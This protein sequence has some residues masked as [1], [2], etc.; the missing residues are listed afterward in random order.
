MNKKNQL[1]IISKTKIV[2]FIAL[3]SMVLSVFTAFNGNTAIKAIA[4]PICASPVNEPLPTTAGATATYTNGL[5]ANYKL[6]SGATLAYANQ[7]I[8]GNNVTGFQIN[9]TSE[10]E[11]KY[12]PVLS[13][14]D[15]VFTDI[16]QTEITTFN[17]YDENNNLIE[18]ITPY[19]T[20]KGTNVVSTSSPIG[21]SLEFTAA[22]NPIAVTDPVGFLR[23]NITQKVSR[24]VIKRAA[25]ALNLNLVFFTLSACIPDP[26][27]APGQIY[28][29]LDDQDQDGVPNWTDL[30][31]DNDG[32]LDS[33]ECAPNNTGDRTYFGFREDLIQSNF[34]AVLAESA[35]GYS[36]YG[37]NI[38]S[39]NGGKDYLVPTPITAAN[40]FTCT[41]TILD[42][43]TSSSGLN[44]NQTFILTTTGLWVYGAEGIAVN[45]SLTSSTTMQQIAL[46]PGVNPTDVKNILATNDPLLILTNSGDIW[47]NGI[48]K[49]AVYGDGSTTSNTAWHKASMPEPAVS[50]RT[51]MGSVIAMTA[52]GKVYT[53]GEK[54]YD[55]VSPSTLG[56]SNVRLP[57]LQTLPAG[58]VPA[59]IAI[60]GI[61]NYP[62]YYVLGTNGKV[63][64]LGANNYGHAGTGNFTNV[65]KWTAVRNSTNTGDLENIRF[66]SAE[67]QDDHWASA[68]AIDNSGQL[69]SWGANDT[70][71]IAGPGGNAPLP[72]KPLGLEGKKVTYVENGGHL[73]PVITTDGLY[74]NTG[75]NVAGGFGDGTSITRT[76]YECNKIPEPLAVFD[77]FCDDDKDGIAN[78]FDLDNDNDTIPDNVESQST[79]GYKAVT[80]DANGK[81]LVG[82]TG[83]PLAYDQTLGN[84]P[85]DT[86][87][88]G[89]P[90]YLDL[91]SDNEGGNDIVEVGNGAADTNNDG[92]TNNP[93]GIN[94]LD[95]TKETADTYV[96]PNGNINIPSALP[97]TQNPATPE[98]DY[99]DLPL[100]P[101]AADDTNTTPLNT[102]ITYNPLANDSYP[103]GTKITSIN[104]ITVVLGTPIIVPN[105]TV[106]VNLDGS[107]TVTPSNGY[108]GDVKFPYVISSVL[109][110]NSTANDTVTI[111]AAGALKLVKAA[112]LIDANADG[113]AQVGEPISYTFT[114]TNSST[115]AVNNITLSDSKCSPIIGGPIATLAPGASDSTTFKCVYKLT[116]GDIIAKKVENQATVQGTDALGN[117]V[118]TKSDSN[119]TTKPGLTDPTVTP[120]ITKAGADLK[121]SKIPDPANASRFS[122]VTW[123]ILVTNDGPE[124][125]VNPV[126]TDT[127]P[128]GL[129]YQSAIP[130]STTSSPRTWTL[131]TLAPGASTTILMKTTVNEITPQTNNASVKSITADPDLTNN[132]T[133]FTLNGNNV[134][135]ADL[136][137]KKTVSPN[138]SKVGDTVTYTIAVTNNGPDDAQNTSVSDTPPAGL[139]ILTTNPT[140]STTPQNYINNGDFEAGNTGFGYNYNYIPDTPTQCQSDAYTG[141][142]SVMDSNACL[143]HARNIY[144]STESDHTTPGTREGNYL[145]VNAGTN[146]IPTNQTVWEQTV[147]GLTPG[148]Q[149]K[150]CWW[151]SDAVMN[152]DV[153]VTFPAANTTIDGVE[154]QK[155]QPF[156]FL[157]TNKDSNWVQYCST[158][159]ADADGASTFKINNL[160]V[161]PAFANLHSND[162]VVDDITLV[163]VTTTGTNYYNTGVIKP[164]ETKLITYTALVTADGPLVN[165]AAV[166]SP[167]DPKDAGANNFATNTL[168]TIKEVPPV[169]IDDTKTT[170]L[171]TPITYAPLANDTY[172]AGSNITKINGITVVLGTPILVPNGTVTVNTDGTVTV[173]PNPGYV[174]DIKFPYEVTTPLGTKA[175]ANNTVTITGTGSVELIKSSTLGDTNANGY[176]DL[177][178]TVKYTFTVRNTGPLALTNV[179]ISDNKCSPIVGSPIATLAVGAS[180]NTAT[181]SYT[182]TAADILLGKV[183]NTATA[184]GTDPT[185]KPVADTSDD[186]NDPT[187]PGANDPTISLLIPKAIDD[188]NT[189]AVN[190]PVT[191]NPLSNDIVPTGSKITAIDGKPVTVG[192][193]IPVLNG[194]VTVNADGT[195]T[196]TP[197]P[198]YVGDIKFPYEVTTPTG[199]KV[200]ATDTVTITGTGAIEIIK[201]S[202]V[203]DTNGNGY[204]DVGDVIKYTFTVK[205][206]GPLVLTNVIISDNKCTPVAGSPIATLAVGASNNSATC[207][208]TL[209][210]ADIATGKV[211]NSATVSGTDP[212]GKQVNDTSDDGNDPTKP[213]LNDPTITLLTPKAIDDTNTTPINTP[214]TYA[215]LANDII[216]TGSKITSIN[217]ITVVPGTPIIVPNG[218]VTVNADG[219]ITV[220]PT[221]GFVGDI[222]FPYEVTT[223]AGV[224]VTANDT[225]TISGIGGIELVKTSTLGDTNANGYTDLGDTI[226]YTFTVKN[227]GTLPLT[228]V[229]ISDSKCSPIVGSPIATLAVGASNNTATCSYT[230]SAL[231]IATGK[232]ENT[233]TVTAKDPTGATL[234]DT[235]DDGNNPA[236]PGSNDPTVT[237]LIPKAVDD[238]NTTPLNT[239]I[240]YSP[241]A[242]DTIPTGSVITSNGQPVPVGVPLPVTNGTVTI[243]ANGT[244]TVTPDKDFVGVITFPYEVTTPQGV[245]V[246]AIDTVTITGSGKVEIIKTSTTID[247]NNNGYADL[248]DKLQYTFMVK[249]VGSLPL[250]DIVIADDKCSPIIGS[251]IATLAVGA[252]NN[253]STCEY[254][255]TQADLNAGKVV[256]TATATGKD[257]SGKVITDISDDGNDITQVGFDD[258][259][260]SLLKPKA[261]DDTKTTPLN[262]PV[263]YAPLANDIV[264]TGSKIVSI[265]GTVAVVGTPILVPNGTVTLNADGTV[266]VTPNQGY[267][268]IIKFPYDVL[269]PTNL[270][271]SATDTVTIT[272]T[273]GVEIAKASTLVDTNGNGY[274]DMGDTIKY[275]FAVKNTGTLP[276]TDVTIVDTK[277]SPITGSPIA[278]LAIGAVDN[279]ATCSYM[280]TAAD[281]NTGKVDN[282]ATVTAKDSSGKVLTDISDDANVPSTPGKDDP[283]ITLL[284]PKAID[285]NNTTPINTPVTYA[286]LTNDTVPTGSKIT[287]IDGKPVTVGTPIQVTN[288]T[289]TVNADGTITVTPNPGYVGD[290]KFPYEVTTP[291]GTKVIA[292]DTVTIT[293]S[294]SIEIIKT[295]V[296]VDTNNNG[297]TDLGD[298]IK[299]TFA[300]KNTGSLALTNVIIT[301]SKCS[302]ITGS[303]IASLLVGASNNSATCS[304]TITAADISIGKV[305]N[306]ATVSGTDPTGKPVT[307]TSDDGNDPTKPG[308]NDPTISLLIPKAIDDTNTTAVNTPV[309]YNPLS[310]DIVPTGS[311]ITAIDGKPVT[312]GTPIPVLNGTVTVNA[313]GTITV[314]PNPGY[315][316]DIKFPYEVT[317]PTVVKVTATDT[318]TITGTGAIELIKSSVFMDK[319][320][321]GTADVGDMIKY[322][323]NVKN[324]GPLALTNVTIT[325]NKCTPITSLPI[326]TLAI[327]SSNNTPTCD[328]TITAAD[329][330]A[331]KVTNSATATGTTPDGK[332]VTDISDDGNNPNT[333]GQV[334]PT[335]TPLTP[336]PIFIE[337]GKLEVIKA[338]QYIDTNNDGQAQAGETIKYTFT[339]KNTGNV[340]LTNVVLIDNKCSPIVGGPIATLTIGATD[341]T[342]FSCTYALLAEDILAGKVENQ[343]IARGQTPK[344]VSVVGISD[345]SDPSKTGPNDVTVTMLPKV[346][347]ANPILEVDKAGTLIDTN[348]NGASEVGE[349]IK[350]TF[351]VKN[352]G[353]VVL[354]NVNITDNKCSVVGGP[355]ASMAVGA[356]D[357][358]TF[359][360]TYIITAADIAAG[361]ADNQAQ[362]SGT[363][364]SGKEVTDLSNDPKTTTPNDVTS[365]L[366]TPKLVD[367][368]R[369]TPFNT[370]ITYSP[371]VND[372]IPAGSTITAI[373]GIPVLIGTPIKVLNGT[374]TVNNDGTVTVTPDTGYT[375]IINFPYEVTTP[376]GIK[377]LADEDITVNGKGMV[378]LDKV[379]SYTD[380]NNDGK[381]GLGET[382]KYAFTIKNTG[383]TILTNVTVTDPMTGIVMMGSPIPSLAPGATNSTA[384]YATYIVTQADLDKG[385]VINQ[386]T[387]SGLDPQGNIVKDL[388]NDPSTTFAKDPTLLLIPKPPILVP[389]PTPCPACTQLPAPSNCSNCP[390]P[391]A[392]M[393]GCNNGCNSGCCMKI[394][395]IKNITNTNTVTITGGSAP[396]LSPVYNYNNV[397]NSNVNFTQGPITFDFSPVTN[398]YYR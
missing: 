318:V 348:S 35:T 337:A 74:C 274:T 242:N 360:C 114:V 132:N 189:T 1:N 256:N 322:T 300:V 244:I 210:A 381:L 116:A 165:K 254:T 271:V 47:T 373:N 134:N 100:P 37:V 264:P 204:S 59:Q 38:G 155:I 289:V 328:Y 370:P 71:M 29:V 166:T 368:S 198:G 115:I 86:D 95:N 101:V 306:T 53:W 380:A 88:D 220:T 258:P 190:T 295:S 149:Y 73:T 280:I 76:Q 119:D 7:P 296:L 126:V 124:P 243:N 216:P 172:P 393:N 146:N 112:Q 67:D 235:S 148:K 378:E 386:A 371:L 28:S 334:D 366:L 128:A 108:L 40:G 72:I 171:N 219:T 42:A 118:T 78:Q 233:A 99:R 168:N 51:W 89:T 57:Y 385:M 329:L 33:V 64:T 215:P 365:I 21:S 174:G 369:V 56:N 344:G 197:N 3:A 157:T 246:T 290:I 390:S 251:P 309:T 106:T 282:T 20:L 313:D 287:A 265:N 221:T 359:T 117:T 55:G 226:K 5:S 358:T 298:T 288:G 193:P 379:A 94:G 279:T 24:I 355:V 98:V 194:T 222:K 345:S 77:L 164:G 206:S 229:I 247:S 175:T 327:G 19:I 208:Y 87:K 331:L 18:D 278:S 177:G 227:S 122:T 228:N 310:N 163:P 241:L 346:I 224:K 212:T 152:W 236:T 361:K 281:I 145:F 286:P 391:C 52:S 311:K 324:T 253:T 284:T 6:L 61:I 192:T 238:N 96:D 285:D 15:Y 48:S 343:A 153:G 178:D 342:T 66:I 181:C 9:P 249:N 356:V 58:V 261:I 127:L 255:L 262:T 91:N 136:D 213:G 44:N 376:T 354:T 340:D 388:S 179:I 277:C 200:T 185:G 336:T 139:T 350:Y 183:E 84:V 17:V 367:D 60:T 16:D 93:V 396:M 294:G 301:D 187:K 263:T 26:S 30:D 167:T 217:G 154:T 151:G 180:N 374:V 330:V 205:N 273:G 196:V 156:P 218:T 207:S 312:V 41:G 10:Y 34:H 357:T 121:I 70:G 191:Y 184:T 323:F 63:Y 317:T 338:S 110:Q 79:A 82:P 363:D 23:L 182:L 160:N 46:P 135:E 31:D 199:V 137:I 22:N 250:T 395:E 230:I 12:T 382:V 353:N 351:T 43:T 339:V 188:T 362:V 27:I 158:Y 283:T 186:G 13:S 237:L 138:P 375:G 292:T 315:V 272:G 142:V 326:A 231:D 83:I 319:N 384:Y 240:T 130:S 252:S 299:Y 293:G 97:N 68:S 131:P 113:A 75:H 320:G 150:F 25:Q 211:E 54:M 14:V 141:S 239:P 107:I 102:P 316:G 69:W 392:G 245:K 90:D 297:Y 140:P 2:A 307:D 147:T 209:T 257:P 111:T 125:A 267:V 201:N 159:T 291:S 314:T 308:A 383:N 49:N 304:Y 170:P 104:G 129:A 65:V 85:V 372:I 225:V 248:G 8:L 389:V 133:A 92:R 62:T 352:T 214:V 176:T 347:P 332:T 203:T 32:I 120:L 80:L 275:T 161:N 4:A 270:I 266:T 397:F 321:N 259:T 169:L 39:N 36:V 144:W 349:I 143:L 105:G 377:L 173:T 103:V 364:P 232:V 341:T 260:V 268:G 303:P 325:D 398:N 335:I 387:V 162:F 11:V 394:N 269:T 202:T 123:T 302:P 223:P 305:E 234:T 195:I 109:G 276:L 50:A 333:P 81:I 45:N